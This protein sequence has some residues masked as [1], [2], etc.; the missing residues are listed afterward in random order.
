LEGGLDN[1]M[2]QVLEKEIERKKVAQRGEEE[3]KL[4]MK[5]AT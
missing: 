3:R 5:K 2:I 4:R 1:V